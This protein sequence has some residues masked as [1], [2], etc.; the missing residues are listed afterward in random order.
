MAQFNLISFLILIPFYSLIIY[1]FHSFMNSQNK[2]LVFSYQMI[3][4]HS[5]S[6]LLLTCGISRFPPNLTF[7]GTQILFKICEYA[8]PHGFRKLQVD[9]YIL[10]LILWGAFQLQAKGLGPLQPLVFL[11]SHIEGN[12]LPPLPYK[13]ELKRKE[14]HQL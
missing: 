14:Y 13:R 9:N 12:S 5:H 10:E 2:A 8:H 3:L 7:M 11:L 4:N 1:L 6:Q